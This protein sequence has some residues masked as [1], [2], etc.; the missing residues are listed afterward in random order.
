[1]RTPSPRRQHAGNIRRN[2]LT[3]STGHASGNPADTPRQ[4]APLYSL[5]NV[6][7]SG[8]GVREGVAHA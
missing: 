3:V 6:L 8:C 1:M 7:A 4:H 2:E 5:R